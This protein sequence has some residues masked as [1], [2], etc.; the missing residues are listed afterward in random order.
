M[1]DGYFADL[2]LEVQD[3]AY[4]LGDD[5]GEEQSTVDRICLEFGL[6]EAEVIAVLQGDYEV[7]V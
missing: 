7:T 2:D 1:L 6:T 3:R 4:E 5:Y